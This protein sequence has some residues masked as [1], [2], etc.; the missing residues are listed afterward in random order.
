MAVRLLDIVSRRRLAYEP[1]SVN[2]GMATRCE[3]MI[4]QGHGF[5]VLEIS[6]FLS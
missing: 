4:Q 5:F 6:D 1:F 2:G 3:S